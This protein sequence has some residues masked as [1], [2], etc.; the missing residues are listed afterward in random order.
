MSYSQYFCKLS[1][2]FIEV[3][4]NEDTEPTKL[5]AFDKYEKSNSKLLF[6]YIIDGNSS[7][8]LLIIGFFVSSD[9][10]YILLNLKLYKIF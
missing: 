4:K 2:N 7:S 8:S 9:I 5:Y 1:L 6:L 10:I 3:S